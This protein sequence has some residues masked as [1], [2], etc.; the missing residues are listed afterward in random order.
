MVL[1]LGT[2]MLMFSD[3][4]LISQ[5]LDM[6]EVGAKIFV[7]T[8]SLLGTT[9]QDSGM[10]EID[11]RSFFSLLLYCLFSFLLFIFFIRLRQQ[12]GTKA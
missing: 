6:A 4:P 9:I 12:S 3:I 7:F 1:L 2:S 11:S 5:R 8:I 10:K